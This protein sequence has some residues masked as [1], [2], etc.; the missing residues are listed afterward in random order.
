MK[1]T[2]SG[3][4]IYSFDLNDDLTF[5]STLAQI[6]KC[7]LRLLESKDPINHRL[8][9]LG[10]DQPANFIELSAVRANEQERIGHVVFFRQSDDLAAHQAEDEREENV[11]PPGFGKGFVQGTD[12]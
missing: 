12:Q 11:Q 1:C 6:I 2:C 8:D 3:L 4:L 10:F 5:R 9:A 7:F